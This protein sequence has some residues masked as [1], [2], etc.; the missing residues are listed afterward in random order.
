[1][2][3][4]R[5]IVEFG[6]GADLHGQDVTKAAV[7]AIKDAISRSCLCGLFDIHQIKNPD[8]MHIKL[9]IGCTDPEK[10]DKEKVISAVPF[11][12]VEL[13]AVQGGLGVQGLC[14]PSLGQGDTIVI[15]VAALTVL[16][17]VS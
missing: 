12:K 1:M 6:M 3:L 16:I 11:G 5:Y 15:A 17:D 10:L 9:K 2:N 14:L 13:E 7:K 8:E 4:Q